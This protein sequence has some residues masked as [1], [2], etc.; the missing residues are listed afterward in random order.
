MNVEEVL[1]VFEGIIQDPK[2]LQ[3]AEE[4][5]GNLLNKQPGFGLITCKVITSSDFD[6]KFR[7]L[8][9]YLIKEVLKDNWMSSSVLI[10]QRQ[11]PFIF[12]CFSFSLGNQRTS[13]KRFG[14]QCQ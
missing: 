1:K 6:I 11:V 7:K 8:T 14:P 5:L 9:G 2:K 4:I 12:H 10:S 13:S 3:N